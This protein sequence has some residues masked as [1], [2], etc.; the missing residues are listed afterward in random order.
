MS[1]EYMITYKMIKLLRYNADKPYVYFC[2]R[3][4]YKSLKSYGDVYACDICDLEF[5]FNGDAKDYSSWKKRSIDTLR[6]G[7]LV[8]SD[9]CDDVNCKTCYPQDKSMIM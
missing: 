3:C 7:K 8:M 2:P 4:G 1:C 6:R 9:L 5:G